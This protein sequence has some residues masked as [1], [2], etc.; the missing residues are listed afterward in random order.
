MVTLTNEQIEAKK[1][2]LKKTIMTLAAVLCCAMTMTVFSACS[3]D[4]DN[5]KDNKDD[6]T[7]AKVAMTF[8][9]YTTQ[10]MLDNCEETIYYNNGYEPR[11]LV[12]NENNIDKNYACE[13]TVA[14]DGLPATFTFKREV[15]LKGSIDSIEKFKY[16]R[17]YAYIYGLYNDAGF[18]INNGESYTSKGGG[19]GAGNKVAEIINASRLNQNFTFTFDKDGKMSTTKE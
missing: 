18:L 10:D 15:K 19:E 2:Q 6:K 5:N 13:I 4:D 9:V 7:P 3:S 8:T 17:G 11:F 12:L 1:Q 14:Y 16:S